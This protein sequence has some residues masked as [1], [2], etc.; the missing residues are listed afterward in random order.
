MS[1][2]IGRTLG[3]YRIVEKIGQGG[4][5]TVYKA[6]QP[7][8]DRYVALKVLPPL[9]AE[10]PGFGERF[11]REAKAIANLN[12]PNILPVHD[13]GQEGEYSFIAMRY[14]EG[15]RTLKE[16]MAGSLSLTQVTN[17]IEQVAAALDYAHRQGIIHRDVK[18]SNVLM[19][20]DWAL[21]TDFGLAKMT[22]ASVKLTGTGVGIGTPA[23]M[24][25]EQGQ[26]LPVDHRTDIYSLG[27]V[28]FEMLTGRIPHDAETPFAIIVKRMSE[29]L[30]L[31]RSLNPAIPEPVE[32]VIL[33]ALA[34]EPDDRFASAA[35][36]AAALKDA[37]SGTA[38]RAFETPPHHAEE[39]PTPPSPE[40][41][42]PPPAP[43][44]WTSPPP[45]PV[46]V[47]VP[48]RSVVPW[49][50]IA[51]VGVGSMLVLTV[52]LFILLLGRGR[53]APEPTS[54]FVAVAVAPAATPTNAP[55][56]TP[57]P[58]LPTSTPLPLVP[59]DAPSPT[60]TRMPTDTPLPATDTPT[61]TP[62][63][64]DTP[65]P[66]ATATS[67]PILLGQNCNSNPGGT[68]INLWQ[69]YRQLLGC[70]ATG[71]QTI[72]T[73]AEEI[74][75]AGHMFWRSDTDEVYVIYD[76]Q[77]DGAELFEGKWQTDPTWKWDGSNPDGIGLYPPPGLYEPKRGFGW[78]W[79]THLG[80][81][82][83]PLGWALDKEYGFDNT[84]QVQAFE[85]G[86]MFKGSSPKL[87][88]LLNNGG[89]FAR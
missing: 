19:D 27:V 34:R 18:P 74:F 28:L 5:A 88:V 46:S 8:L 53:P 45:P 64:T 60:P 20:G 23:Y 25:P 62:A 78:L 72:P 50:W 22:E 26:G 33:K 30:P 85:Q 39:R 80:A 66:T 10:Q 40:R 79:R 63:P 84:G 51:G 87:Y 35:A 86:I 15:A 9:H 52:G 69:D 58:V 83:G 16:V 17:L 82:D 24:S 57:V 37:L 76:R 56:D 32:R 14:I 36:M 81:A 3:Q 2:L 6:Y 71:Q 49:K 54:T 47:P 68:F 77:K 89:F 21:L 42:T 70:P 11:R 44:G 38:A 1:E 4:M 12:H 55:P 67:T 61:A 41:V 29:P 13:F 31:P 59:T 65:T 43:A 48:A 75:Q 7:G 73:M